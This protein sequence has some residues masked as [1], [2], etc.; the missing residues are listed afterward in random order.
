MLVITQFERSKV[1]IT[2]STTFDSTVV[3]ADD[4]SFIDILNEVISKDEERGA[5]CEQTFLSKIYPKLEDNLKSNTDK[6]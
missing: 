5:K 4:D 2:T 3:T 6:S 1:H